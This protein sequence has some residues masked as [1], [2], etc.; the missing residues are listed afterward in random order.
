MLAAQLPDGPPR[1]PRAQQR[2]RRRDARVDLAER[3]GRAGRLQAPPGP[4]PPHQPHRPTR[5]RHVDQR[6]LP[7]AAGTS[8]HTAVPTAHRR[9]RRLHHHPQP[10]VPGHVDGDDVDAC[11]AEQEV[12][13]V[14]V[15]SADTSGAGAGA[16]VVARRR[17]G[18]VEA[19]RG[20]LLGRSR[21][22]K[23]STSP[24]LNSHPRVP[25]PPQVR[26]APCVYKDLNG[27]LTQVVTAVSAPCP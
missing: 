7:T 16:R 19:F 12:A 17:L 24:P 4:L 11:Q 21:S 5:A 2:P 22:W 14:A 10:A 13:A 26:R 15:T 27:R 6:H 3:A 1:R 20:G 9:R 18:H 23:A 8:Q 25:A